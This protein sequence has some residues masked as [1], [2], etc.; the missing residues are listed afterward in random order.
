ME[1]N[2][3]FAKKKIARLKT[4]AAFTLTCFVMKTK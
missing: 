4:R 1:L 2:F 3:L